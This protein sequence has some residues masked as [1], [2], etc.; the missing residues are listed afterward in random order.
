MFFRDI[1]GWGAYFW[2][3]DF[4]KQKAG[5]LQSEKRGD[6]LSTGQYLCKVTFAGMAG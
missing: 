2:A 5:I 6:P 4:M 3:Y 1:P